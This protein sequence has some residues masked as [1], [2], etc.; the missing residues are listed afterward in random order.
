MHSYRTLLN[1]VDIFVARVMALPGIQKTLPMLQGR[2]LTRDFTATYC[3]NASMLRNMSRNK[4][5]RSKGEQN[6]INFNVTKFFIY[7]LYQLMRIHSSLKCCFTTGE[8]KQW[9]L[10][11]RFTQRRVEKWQLKY[12]TEGRKQ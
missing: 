1:R 10:C 7:H 5:C 8:Y 9:S 3:D 2:D 4:L 6:W 11:Y 12:G